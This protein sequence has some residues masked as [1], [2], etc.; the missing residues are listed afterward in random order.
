MKAIQAQL[1]RGYARWEHH[2]TTVEGAEEAIA[3][4]GISF[5]LWRLYQHFW[6]IC[7]LFP[8]VSLVQT[9]LAPVRLFLALAALVFFA[10]SY[11]WLMWPHPASSGA[12]KRS[13]S[14]LSLILFAALIALVLMLSLTY[15]PA[16]LWLFIGISAIAG[17]LLPI[18]GA[19]VV[20]TV[21]MFLPLFISIGITGG[22]TKVNWL[23]LVPLMLL[24]RGLGLDMIGSARLFSA[25]RE[26]HATRAELARLAVMEE[27]VRLARD[28]HDLLGHT[29]SMITLKS[30]LAR[31]LVEQEPARAVQEM[32]EVERA[33]RQTLR[34]VREAVA[35]YRQPRLESELDGARQ[36]LSAAGIACQV[37]Y[38]AGTL[39]PSTDAVLAWTVREGVTNV[40]RHSHARNCLIRLS[41]ENGTICAE[42]IN[43][44]SRR[45]ESEGAKASKGLGLSGLSERVTSR[46]GHMEAGPL[47]TT[48]NEDFRL[49]V[50]LPIQ[51]HGEALQEEQS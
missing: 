4:S 27:R 22:I 43:D 26:L 14:R 30:E 24:V 1:A 2:L 38:T 47:R 5:L 16:F 40:I 31:R 11:T 13:L 46:G 44:G 50:E 3:S 23:Q 28:L 51:S 45:Q 48:G 25:I 35:G 6:L 10:A 19:L 41:K 12:R 7:L 42:V 18:R 37:E 33:S 15:G 8:I 39:D 29:L 21:L 9:S 49:W 36:I 17:V 34:E 20:V 32:R